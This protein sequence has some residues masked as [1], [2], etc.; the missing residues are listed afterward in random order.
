MDELEMAAEKKA[1]V[2]VADLEFVVS[3]AAADATAA[4]AGPLLANSEQP[5]SPLAQ[6]ENQLQRT[7]EA[8]YVPASG[9]R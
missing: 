7:T 6:A 8:Y 4:A 9:T 5:P 3:S 1:T 2:A